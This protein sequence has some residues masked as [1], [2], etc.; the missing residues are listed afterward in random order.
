MCAF[1]RSL[2]VSKVAMRGWIATWALIGW[3][4]IPGTVDAI[5]AQEMASRL[6]FAPTSGRTLGVFFQQHLQAV[7]EAI[8][9]VES[10]ADDQ[11]CD[12]H[13]LEQELI[14]ALG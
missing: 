12:I 13:F 14:P 5:R 4:R 6:P 9:L 11:L 2:L 1:K 3:N 10:V 7:P 8:A